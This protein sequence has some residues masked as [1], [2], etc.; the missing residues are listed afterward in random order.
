MVPAASS[1]LGA[2]NCEL[3]SLDI[4]EFNPFEGSEGVM[5]ALIAD[6]G[7]GEVKVLSWCAVNAPSNGTDDF[8]L[9]TE[10]S[11]RFIRVRFAQK[12]C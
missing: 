7:Q 8:V 4:V 11:L 9:E 10:P 1:T 6:E 12:D 2:F 5:E 3:G